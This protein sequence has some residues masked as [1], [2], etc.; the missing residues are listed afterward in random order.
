MF[1]SAENTVLDYTDMMTDTEG[2][3]V[4]FLDIKTDIKQYATVI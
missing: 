3:K 2:K 4:Y 1:M